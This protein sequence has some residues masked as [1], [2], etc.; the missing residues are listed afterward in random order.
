M[1][2]TEVASRNQLKVITQKE[3]LEIF[4]F[5]KTKLQQ[6]LNAGVLPVVKVGKTYL[7]S[8]TLILRWLDE[9]IGK[10]VFY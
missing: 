2:I 1:K 6:L 7:S 4:P 5:K 3:L 9:N 10:E 8:D